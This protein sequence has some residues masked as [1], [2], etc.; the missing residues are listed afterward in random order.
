MPPNNS[1]N[2]WPGPNNASNWP[3][4]PEKKAEWTGSASGGN[5]AWGDPRGVAMDPRE[6]SRDMMRTVFCF[7][8]FSFLLL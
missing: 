3:A 6:M 7:C 1:N 4:A 2:S 8:Y 5:A